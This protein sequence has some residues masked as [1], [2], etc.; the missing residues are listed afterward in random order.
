MY[1]QSQCPN[2][3]GR[4]AFDYGWLRVTIGAG[5]WARKPGRGKLWLV[6]AVGIDGDLDSLAAP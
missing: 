2:C 1:N 4:G 5:L 6:L 3:F